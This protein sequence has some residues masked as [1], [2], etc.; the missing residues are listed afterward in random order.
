[1]TCPSCDGKQIELPEPGYPAWCPDCDSW[2][3]KV[4]E[5]G[6]FD[7]V[8]EIYVPMVKGES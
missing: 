5:A 2:F 1:M 4:D 6:W 8:V 7:Y 3:R